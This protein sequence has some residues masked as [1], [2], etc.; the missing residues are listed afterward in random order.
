MLR[1]FASQAFM[2]FIMVQRVAGALDFVF[3]QIIYD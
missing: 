1:C 2:G 3:G